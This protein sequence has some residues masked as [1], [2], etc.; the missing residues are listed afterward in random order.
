[1]ATYDAGER[2][3]RAADE[4]SASQTARRRA[5][6]LAF[7]GSRKDRRDL[8]DTERYVRELR[9]DTRMQRLKG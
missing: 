5:A 7:V 8:P 3:H 9:K 1:M 6:M 4:R 2:D